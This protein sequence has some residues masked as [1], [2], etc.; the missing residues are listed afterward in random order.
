M[1]Q[2]FLQIGIDVCKAWLDVWALPLSSKC[3][4]FSNN[5]EGFA[6]LIAWLS[7]LGGAIGRV[8]LEAT[9]GYE[10]EVAKALLDADFT[11]VIVDPLRI[12]R[13]AQAS[14]RRAKNDAIDARVIAEFL[15]A[16]ADRLPAWH[17][18]AE[19]DLLSRLSRKRAAVLQMRTAV[20][21]AA[22][23]SSH[24]LLA[25]LDR[26]MLRTLDAAI[27]TLD[28]A[29]S[30]LIS[31]VERFA[32]LEQRLRT[33]KCVG[34]VLAATAIAELPELGTVSDKRLAALVGVAPFDDDSGKSKGRR[35][36]AGGRPA[37]RK[38]LYMAAMT[39]ATRHNP[40]LKAIYDRLVARGKPAKV[41]LIACMRHL[42]CMLNLIARRGWGW[43]DDP[44]FAQ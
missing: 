26:A 8:G 44:G 15:A 9:G 2:I 4:R 29:I 6:D 41:A 12:R 14:G 36:I 30:E 3:R 1:S 33:I 38:A 22:P 28:R 23:G 17:Y 37:I 39:G 27:A 31:G 19:R 20:L 32:L 43:M 35:R 5:D 7:A 34:P 25:R 11:V 40:F 42:L 24:R 10:S 18:D 13:F 16:F 21:N